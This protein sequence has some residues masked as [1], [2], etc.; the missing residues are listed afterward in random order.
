MAMKKRILLSSFFL[1]LTSAFLCAQKKVHL[2]STDDWLYDKSLIDAQR[3]VGN[4][5][6]E[7]EGTHFFA[8]SAYLFPNDNFDAFGQIRMNKAN[9]YTLTGRTL[10][11]EEATH[12]ATVREDVTLRDGQMTL[13]TNHLNYHTRSGIATYQGGG[14]MVSSK[15][16]NQL[17]SE[18]GSYHS[19]TQVF[20]FRNQVQLKNPQYKVYSDTLEYNELNETAYFFGP[21][22]IVGDSTRLYCENGYYNTKLDQSRFGKNAQVISGKIKLRGDSIY[23]N[24]LL[25]VGEVFRNVSITDTTARVQIHGNYGKHREADAYSF[26][27]EKSWLYQDL[28]QGDSLFVRADSLFLLGEQENHHQMRA[29]HNVSFFHSEIQGICDSLLFFEKDSLLELHHA[30]VMWHSDNQLTCDTVML[31]L[32]N[33]APD[34]MFMRN[35]AFILGKAIEKSTVVSDSSLLHQIKGRNMMGQFVAGEMRTLNVEGNAQLIY[36]PESD[37]KEKPHIIGHNKGDCSQILI[38]LGQRQIQKIRL[39]NEPRSVYSP[40][41]KVKADDYLLSGAKWDDKLRPLSSLW[42]RSFVP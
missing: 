6:L 16:Q 12:T 27:T 10:H 24:G 28:G 7:Y 35:N 26:V 37:V 30:P 2:I 3:L 9:E 22:H 4:V 39:E 32:K 15:D 31:Y 36:F 34:R 14:K 41:S 29:Y 18:R 33:G 23:Y 40:L 8:D 42:I 25:G 1:L 11:F 19:K 20:Y 17:T 5:H 38:T 13:Q 21:T